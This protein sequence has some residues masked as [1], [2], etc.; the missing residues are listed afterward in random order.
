MARHYQ[1][2]PLETAARQLNLAA[3]MIKRGITY[4]IH[5]AERRF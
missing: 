3:K 4:S 1:I 5:I 2:R